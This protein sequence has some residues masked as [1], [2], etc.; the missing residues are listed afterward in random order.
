[1]VDTRTVLNCNGCDSQ[2]TES[3][4]VTFPLIVGG[5]TYTITI[6]LTNTIPFGGG[7]IDFHDSGALAC[8]GIG[9]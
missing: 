8:I 4:L 3:G 6:G 2:V 9:P 5:G 1:M 7:S